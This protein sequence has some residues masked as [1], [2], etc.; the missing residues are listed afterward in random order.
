MVKLI[1]ICD[2]CK[3]EIEE[4]ITLSSIKYQEVCFCEKCLDKLLATS[5]SEP[6]P[7]PPA[8][9]SPEEPEK[10]ATK[11][12]AKRG[13]YDTR[14]YDVPKMLAL[15]NAGWSNAQIADEFGIDDPEKISKIIWYHKNKNKAT[16]SIT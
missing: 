16:Q 14:K 4:P 7:T 2:I 10:A 6:E 12:S 5:E 9:E 3:K 15:K 8:G 1:Y 11:E 13:S